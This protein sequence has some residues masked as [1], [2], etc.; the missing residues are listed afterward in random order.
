[1]PPSSAPEG[2]FE[3]PFDRILR[4][5]AIRHLS[6]QSLRPVVHASHVIVPLNMTF[7]SFLASKSFALIIVL[8]APSSSP[9]PTRHQGPF[10]KVPKALVRV[11]IEHYLALLQPDGPGGKF[12]PL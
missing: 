9:C 11:L 10:A 1:M 6:L 7:E 3:G 8:L 2:W 12:L 4:N 5:T